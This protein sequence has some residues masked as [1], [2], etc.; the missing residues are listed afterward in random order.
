M[1]GYVIID[2]EIIEPEE[3]SAFVEKSQA[4]IAAH[5]GSFLVR[6]SDVETFQGGWTPKRLVVL[7]FDNLESARGFLYSDEYG[8]LDE[9]RRRVSNSRI[10]VVEG[11]DL[12]S[13]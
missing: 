2:T 9:V 1:K 13:D 10:V 6:S 3:Y 7:E 8:A 5:G 11:D 12:G 4:A